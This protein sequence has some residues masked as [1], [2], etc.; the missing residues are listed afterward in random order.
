MVRSAPVAWEVELRTEKVSLF[1]SSK[2]PHMEAT[3]LHLSQGGHYHFATLR[4]GDLGRSE[5][6]SAELCDPAGGSHRVKARQCSGRPRRCRAPASQVP[7]S[8]GL[9]GRCEHIAIGGER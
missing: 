3:R 8:D 1:V 2:V 4:K 5:P 9:V 6:G 7:N